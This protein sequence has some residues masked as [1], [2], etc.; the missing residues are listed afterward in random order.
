MRNDI[1]SQ[2]ESWSQLTG[3][4]DDTGYQASSVLG[5]VRR[6]GIAR[7]VETGSGWFEFN[8]K[9]RNCKSYEECG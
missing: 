3:V 7:V 4:G 2:G 6:V 9:F 1:K 8:K 5:L